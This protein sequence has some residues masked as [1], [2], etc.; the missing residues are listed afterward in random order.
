MMMMMMIATLSVRCWGCPLR[1]WKVF[2]IGERN[3]GQLS[4]NK[5]PPVGH[6]GPLWF[7]CMWKQNP[8]C[9]SSVCILISEAHRRRWWQLDWDGRK[10]TGEGPSVAR[11]RRESK[12][13]RRGH[14][15]RYTWQFTVWGSSQRRCV[16]AM[17]KGLE[18]STS[19]GFSL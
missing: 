4:W 2:S 1:R 16:G 6:C 18:S 11:W 19:S 13:W 14:R 17:M 9:P 3:K 5:H 12:R 8:A 7:V 10:S 15:N